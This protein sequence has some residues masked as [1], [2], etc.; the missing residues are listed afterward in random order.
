[1]H[2]SAPNC[3]FVCPGIG[4]PS[5]VWLWRQ[6]RGIKRLNV[7]VVTWENKLQAGLM[8]SVH[9]LPFERAPYNGRGRWLYRLRC[10]P[11]RNFYATV[12][13]ER[14]MLADRLRQTKPDVIFCHYGYFGLRILPLVDTFHVPLVVH[15][16]GLDISLHN[17]WYR[18]SLL[19]ALPRF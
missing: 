12:G 2:V 16:N 18:W 6:L 13:A 14:K 19:R 1:M 10:L 17:R 5:E 11:E 4:R 7:N 8:D 3:W 15:F 9:V